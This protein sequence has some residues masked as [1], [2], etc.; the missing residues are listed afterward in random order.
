MKLIYSTL[1]TL[2]IGLGGYLNSYG[3]AAEDLARLLG[4]AQARARDEVLEQ[5]NVLGDLALLEPLKLV[6]LERD[7]L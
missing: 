3:A 2:G 1:L 6:H 5:R 4:H 7:A